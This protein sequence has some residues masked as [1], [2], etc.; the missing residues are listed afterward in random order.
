MLYMVEIFK[1]TVKKSAKVKVALSKLIPSYD[2]QGPLLDAMGVVG[3]LFGS[4]KM[5]LPQVIKS[6]R[7]MKKAV[8][9]LEPFIDK[10]KGNHCL[11]AL[12]PLSTGEWS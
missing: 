7:V 6:A 11:T 5:F 4:G 9:Y 1:K 10:K 2:H 3:D 12:T 8:A